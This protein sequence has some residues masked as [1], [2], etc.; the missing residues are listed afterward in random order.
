MFPDSGYQSLKT[1]STDIEVLEL[2]HNN[3]FKS[4]IINALDRLTNLTNLRLK[5]SDSLRG[6]SCAPCKPFF[7]AIKQL[8]KLNRLELINFFA[9]ADLLHELKFCSRTKFVLITTLS[10]NMPRVNILL[11]I[12]CSY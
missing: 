11:Y 3:C 12:Q 7:T 9:H 4:D 1:L 10:C 6:P 5:N 8:G 2:E